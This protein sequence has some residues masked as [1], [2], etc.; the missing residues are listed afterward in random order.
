MVT[1]LGLHI[2]LAKCTFI[3]SN[4]INKAI[5]DIVHNSFSVLSPDGQFE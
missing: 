4:I 1:K 2:Y 3:K 5:V